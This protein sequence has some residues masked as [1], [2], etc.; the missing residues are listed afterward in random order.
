MH[1]YFDKNRIESYVLCTCM[2]SSLANMHGYFDES[3][4]ELRM[5][6]SLANMHGY[7]D[8]SNRE[9]HAMDLYDL[10]ASEHARVF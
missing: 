10:L 9:L 7:F 5:I 2:I 3:N 4:R 1:G 6:S 8:E